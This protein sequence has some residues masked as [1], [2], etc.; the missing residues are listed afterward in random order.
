MTSGEDVTITDGGPVSGSADS[1]IVPRLWE[2]EHP[3]RCATGNFYNVNQHTEYGSWEEFVEDRG[4]LHLDWAL[5]FRWDWR[6]DRWHKDPADL[7][8]YAARFGDH[9]HAWTLQIFWLLQDK[10]IFHCSEISVCKADEPAVRAWL[11]IRANHM[12]AL[13]EPLIGTAA[14]V[15]TETIMGDK[16][17]A[18]VLVVDAARDLHGRARA[19][20]RPGAPDHDYRLHLILSDSEVSLHEGATAADVIE[21]L[22][23]DAQRKESN[24]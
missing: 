19:V 5:V 18:T 21:Y 14:P 9:D 4:D 24:L 16:V 6:P 12:R 3:Y 22:Q 1:A 11:T 10:G 23:R 17:L 15:A 2:I 20:L 7:R 8:G 13:W